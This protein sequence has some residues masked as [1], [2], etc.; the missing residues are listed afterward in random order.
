MKKVLLTTTALT[1]AAGV[2]SAEITFS[3]K[4]EAGFYRNAPTAAVAAGTAPTAG[5][6]SATY[7]GAGPADDT[8]AISFSAT[9]ALANNVAASDEGTLRAAYVLALNAFNEG[10]TQATLEALQK[11]QMELE[12][13]ELNQAYQTASAAV[14]KGATPTLS[15][16]S[17][18]DMNAAVSGASDNGMTFSFGFDMGAG[19]I[20]DQ[21]DDRAMDAQGAAVTNDQLTIGYA[22][23]TIEIGDDLI[24]DVYDDSQNGDVALSGSLGDL[25]FKIVHDMDKD[26]E[27]VAATYASYSATAAD[28]VGT[29]TAGTAA[30]AAVYNTTSYSVGYTMGDDAI[31][32]ASKDPDDRGNAAAALSLTD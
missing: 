10:A 14:A 26:V 1:L 22:G 24:D 5:A 7:T 21:D 9:A 30:T 6:Y 29:Y 28:L 2:A 17:G 18:Y 8:G 19:M 12:V 23:Y 4:G 31:G 20:A 3:G 32:K 27:A 13:L 16:Y 25:T 11:A 15:A